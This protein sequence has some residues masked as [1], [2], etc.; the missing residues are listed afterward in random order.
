MPHIQDILVFVK[1]EEPGVNGLGQLVDGRVIKVNVNAVQEAHA[2]LIRND[3]KLSADEISVA[4]LVDNQTP[5][6]GNRSAQVRIIGLNVLHGILIAER[7]TFNTSDDIIKEVVAKVVNLNLTN[8][9]VLGGHEVDSTNCE[10][11][12]ISHKR[13]DLTV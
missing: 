13:A 9:G 5:I 7:D 3:N 2:D 10:L 8:D 4:A 12:T 11:D 6:S 1:D